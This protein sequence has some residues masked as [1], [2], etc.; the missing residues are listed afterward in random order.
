MTLRLARAPRPPPQLDKRSLI[1]EAA[2]AVFIE[3]GYGAARMEDI[4]E[5]AGVAKQTLYNHFGSKDALF[6][7]IIRAICES[8]LVSIDDL[9][10]ATQPAPEALLGL[11]HQ[12]AKLLLAP[13]SLGL[14]RLLIAESPRFPELGQVTYRSGGQQLVERLAGFLR[15]RTEAGELDVADPE[16][17]AEQFYGMITGYIQVRALLGVEAE[18]EPA[19]VEKAMCLAV[20]AFVAAYRAGPPARRGAVHQ[21]RREPA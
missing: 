21:R 20:D 9:P 1:L 19:R 17:A 18:P 7:A 16:I 14:Y 8:L 5:R 6:E 10:E 11:A 13:W 15:G 4:A 3:C 12:Y 2:R